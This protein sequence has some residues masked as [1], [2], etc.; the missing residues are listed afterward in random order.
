MCLVLKSS[1]EVEGKVSE[2]WG[3]FEVEGDERGKWWLCFC[4]FDRGF[5]WGEGG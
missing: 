5:L 2:Q 4:C 1:L 3:V